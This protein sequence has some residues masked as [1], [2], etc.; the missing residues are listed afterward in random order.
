MPMMFDRT[1]R[2]SAQHL[3]V[4]LGSGV[5]SRFLDMLNREL[6]RLSFFTEFDPRLFADGMDLVMGTCGGP[7]GS[8]GSPFR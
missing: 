5:S 7:F 3:P 2:R 1:V 4:S 8:S 6:L